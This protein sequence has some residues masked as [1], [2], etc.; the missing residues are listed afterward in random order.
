MDSPELLAGYGEHAFGQNHSLHE[1]F[2]QNVDCLF[3]KI[4]QGE[5][6]CAKLYEDQDIL[7]FL[8]IGPVAK[9][10]A[11]VIPKAHFADIWELP[12]SL[13]QAMISAIQKVGRGMTAALGAQGLNVGMNNGKAAGQLIFHAHWHLIP[14]F[15]DDG[16]GAWP[17]ASYASPDEMRDLAQAIA[18]HIL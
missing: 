18:K 15:L 10:H 17:Q 8:D 5:I 2:M 9:G 7:A 12:P 1:V 4:V 16:L 3:C 13:A 6:P 14:R 11:L